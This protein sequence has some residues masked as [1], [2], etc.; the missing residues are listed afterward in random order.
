MSIKEKEKQK[1]KQLMDSHEKLLSKLKELYQ[2]K[3][4]QMGNEIEKQNLND[5]EK[6]DKIDKRD[7]KLKEKWAIIENK[8]KKVEDKFR[9][10]NDK[11]T[12][13]ENKVNVGDEMD[14]ISERK[15]SKKV[16]DDDDKVEEKY[17]KPLEENEKKDKNSIAEIK[18]SGTP[19][20]NIIVRI[21]CVAKNN[22]EKEQLLP[23]EKFILPI[24]LKISSDRETN[25]KAQSNALIIS[26]R[27][28]N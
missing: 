22:N 4:I 7:K 26:Q 12:K 11:T 28:N 27:K 24:L 21:G 5:Y 17:L 20:R 15:N 9:K 23:K 18:L 10:I 2:I 8:C 19:S 14:E 13:K 6:C 25:I 16:D 3:K 1:M